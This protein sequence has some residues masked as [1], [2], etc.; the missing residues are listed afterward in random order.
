MKTSNSQSLENQ[1][2]EERPKIQSKL[3]WAFD[4]PRKDAKKQARVYG[5]KFFNILE[6]KLCNKDYKYLKCLKSDKPCCKHLI[7]KLEKPDLH[8][9]QFPERKHHLKG[10]KV[11][12]NSKTRLYLKRKFWSHIAPQI[13]AI[14]YVSNEITNLQHLITKTSASNYRKLRNISFPIIKHFADFYGKLFTFFLKLNKLKSLEFNFTSAFSTE[15][16]QQ[17]LQNLGHLDKLRALNLNLKSHDANDLDFVFKNL[18]NLRE[19]SF[20]GLQ[21]GKLCNKKV[22]ESLVAHEIQVTKSLQNISHLEL[23]TYVA[24]PYFQ[25]F[26]QFLNVLETLSSLISLNLTINRCKTSLNELIMLNGSSIILSKLKYLSLE[27][28]SQGV[29]FDLANYFLKPI[30]NL[31][32]CNLKNIELTEDLVDCIFQN[33]EMK[34]LKIVYEKEFQTNSLQKLCLNIGKL[35]NLQLFSIQLHSE[36]VLSFDF[37]SLVKGVSHLKKVDTIVVEIVFPISIKPTLFNKFIDVLSKIKTLSAV[38]IELRLQNLI[39][40]SSIRKLFLKDNIDIITVTVENMKL[41]KD[42]EKFIKENMKKLKKLISCKIECEDL[43]I[44]RRF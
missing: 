27:G 3:L 13:T 22:Q 41:T 32:V 16:T 33:K 2:P 25:T 9:R 31:Q 42:D 18:C 40:G 30:C 8:L 24:S 28:Y 37:E 1:F 34:E 23:E 15:E 38:E 6:V 43:K 10:L 39:K 36:N 20:L 7:L 11:V 17:I 5:T 21:L 19:L 12:I 4:S 35:E 44:D 26:Q 29:G 14:D